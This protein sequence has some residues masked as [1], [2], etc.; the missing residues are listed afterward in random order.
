M[1]MVGGQKSKEQNDRIMCEDMVASITN[2]LLAG[3]II[4]SLRARRAWQSH[5]IRIFN[6]LRGHSAGD[7]FVV[8]LLAMTVNGSYGCR[9]F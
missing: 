5:F 7:C 4:K 1:S 8:T 3:L 6:Y 2:Y 9:R